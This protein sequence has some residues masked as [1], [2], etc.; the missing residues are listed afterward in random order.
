[1]PDP[2]PPL[3]TAAVAEAILRA[4]EAG[5]ARIE[6]SLDLNL[7]VEAIALDSSGADLRG[8]AVSAEGL[9]RVLKRPSVAFAVEDDGLYP[10]EVRGEGYAKLV[11]T[12]GAPTFELSG[13]QMH[14]TSG[15]DPFEDARTKAAAVVEPGNTVLDTCGG[16]GYTALWA[17]R[18]GAA[19]VVSIE[20]SPVAAPW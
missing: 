7:G 13:V 15:I 16:A 19:R 3:I 14:R 4:I 12:S 17:L 20:A 1:M 8:V 18:L 11:P 2:L 9:R 10:V 6:A 5:E